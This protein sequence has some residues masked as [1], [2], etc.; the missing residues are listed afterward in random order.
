MWSGEMRISV[1]G[2]SVNVVWC[3]YVWCENEHTVCV[4][5]SVCGV[6]M[7]MCGECMMCVMHICVQCV[8][9]L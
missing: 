3:V 8:C 4:H 7:F 5:C 1:C 9:A 6:G 2:V